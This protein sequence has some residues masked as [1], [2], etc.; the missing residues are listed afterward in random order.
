[1]M[2]RVLSLVALLLIPFLATGQGANPPADQKAAAKPATTS[3]AK[4]TGQ[5]RFDFNHDSTGFRLDG[6]HLH[7]RCESCHV[8]GFFRGTPKTCNTC[9]TVGQVWSTVVVQNPAHIN[10]PPNVTCDTCHVSTTSFRVWRMDHTVTSAL[11]STCHSGQNFEGVVPTTKPFTH[12]QTTADCSLCHQTSLQTNQFKTAPLQLSGANSAAWGIPLGSG[13]GFG[14]NIKYYDHTGVIANCASCHNGA[15]AQGKPIGH[16]PTSLPCEQCH[17]TIPVRTTQPTSFQI[18][19]MD[20]TGIVSGCA[21]CHNGQSFLGV[22]PMAKPAG[23]IPTTLPCEDCHTQ[24]SSGIQVPGGFAAATATFDH[25]ANHVLPGTCTSCHNGTAAMGQIAGHIAT[26]GGTQCDVCHNMTSASFSLWTMGNTGHASVSAACTNCHATGRTFPG[27]TMVTLP[28]GALHI[29]TAAQCGNCHSSK[30]TFTS[31]TMDHTGIASGCATCHNTGAPYPGGI[32][33]KPASGHIPTSKPCEACHT[34]T[35]TPG[36]FQTWHMDHTGIA[37]GCA[38]CHDT[39]ASFTPWSGTA[40]VTKPVGHIPTT[41]ACENCHP[42]SQ[43]NVGGFVLPITGMNHTG[44][45]SNCSSCHNGSTFTNVTPVYK[46]TNHVLTSQDCSAC[47]TSTTIPGGFAASASSFD[48]VKAGVQPGTCNTCHNGT[49]AT[50]MIGG[51]IGVNVGSKCDACHS[52]TLGSF[53]KWTMDHTKVSTTCSNCHAA[54]SSFPGATM[55]TIG[56]V[57]HVPTTAPCSGC[58]S[59]TT[60]PGGFA[61]WTMDH[62]QVAGTACATCHDTGKSFTGSTAVVTKPT[63]HIPVGSTACDQCHT[64]TTIPNGFRT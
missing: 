42:A 16:I 26:N 58:H 47:H 8:K 28:T 9:H 61:T 5:G 17:T 33:T 15:S 27:A 18:W 59:S 38:S 41:S 50:G 10:V 43:T 20:H 12:P 2:R 52:Y 48:H 62:S 36:G 49:N 53:S 56:T 13:V 19:T 40:L 55:V 64:S 4:P 46:P 57:N 54:G 24:R 25:A 60:V 1:M 34:S 23:H 22:T 14:L 51:H 44:I 29:P 32:V 63:G 45:V 35:A 37:T 3:A 39:G 30:T 21:S 11:C 6:A 31:W 7:A